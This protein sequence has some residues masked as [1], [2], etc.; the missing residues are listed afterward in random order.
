MKTDCRVEIKADDGDEHHQ[1]DERRQKKMCVAVLVK[2]P[3]VDAEDHIPAVLGA[4]AEDGV[5]GAVDL[6]DETVFIVFV[7]DALENGLVLGELGGNFFA[8]E[9]HIGVPDDH[10]VLVDDEGGVIVVGAHS[11]SAPLY[12]LRSG[13]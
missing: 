10:A 2:R 9:R 11:S 5:V 6:G 3:L 1:A 12:Q 8:D 13:A 7:D 4:T